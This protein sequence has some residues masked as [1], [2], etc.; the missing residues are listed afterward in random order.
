[1]EKASAPKKPAKSRTERDSFPNTG[2][3]PVSRD[4]LVRSP[5]RRPESAMSHGPGPPPIGAGAPTVETL[6]L[7]AL[8]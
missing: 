5:C 6:W 7:G 1:M 2:G 4:T 8:N 3:V